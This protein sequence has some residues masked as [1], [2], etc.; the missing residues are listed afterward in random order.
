MPS[1]PAGFT[2][3][4][5]ALVT[6]SDALRRRRHQVGTRWRRLTIGRQALLVVAHLRKGETHTDFAAV[7]SRG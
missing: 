5:H 7:R 1:C 4:D 6:L 3:S 2:M